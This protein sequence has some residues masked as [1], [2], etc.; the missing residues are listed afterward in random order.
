VRS[1]TSQLYIGPRV[2][3]ILSNAKCPVIVVNS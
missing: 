2:E 3:R 1:G